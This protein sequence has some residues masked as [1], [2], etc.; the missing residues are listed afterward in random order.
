M[1]EGIAV[2]LAIG[3]K[4][5]FVGKLLLFLSELAA[6]E[7]SDREMAYPASRSYVSFYAGNQIQHN[8]VSQI[9]GLI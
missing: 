6:L 1:N 9:Q 3:L 7:P 2:G 5:L 8:F 4:P